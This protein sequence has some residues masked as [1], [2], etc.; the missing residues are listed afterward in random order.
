MRLRSFATIVAALSLST[1]AHAQTATQAQTVG[2]PAAAATVPANGPMSDNPEAR[3]RWE[4]FRAVCG[5]DL[6]THCATV[7]RGTEQARGEMRQ[8]IETHKAKFAKDCQAAIAER[9]AAREARKQ[10][11]EASKPKS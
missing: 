3:A 8:C 11:P 10:A 5:K 2:Q 1:L 6:Q 9:D 4:K 7:A